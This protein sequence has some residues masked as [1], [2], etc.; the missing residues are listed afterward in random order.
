MVICWERAN[1][2]ALFYVMFLCV[3][4]Y[5]C[6]VLGQV[7]YLIVSISDPCILTLNVMLSFCVL[8]KGLGS[9]RFLYLVVSECSDQLPFDYTLH[10]LGSVLAS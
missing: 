7:G 5:P 6:G 9:M 2:L 3:V 4:T 1:L 8:K 10:Q